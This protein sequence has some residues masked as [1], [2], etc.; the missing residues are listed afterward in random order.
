MSD[1]KSPGDKV[2]YV[3]YAL[4]ILLILAD[5]VDHKHPHFSA[6][7]WFGFYGLFGFAACVAL[8]LAAA[9]LRLIFKRG[10]DYYD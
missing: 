7:G 5:V 3:L 9:G 6:E 2:C 4:C 10:E 1:K 8:V